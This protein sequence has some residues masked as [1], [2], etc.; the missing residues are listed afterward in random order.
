MKNTDIGFKLILI[1]DRIN[2]KK[3][4]LSFIKFACNLGVKAIQLREK[5]LE[6]RKLL[7]LANSLRKITSK[8]DTLLIINDRIDVALLSNADGLHS[9]VDGLI[10]DDIKRYKTKFIFGK[11]VHSKISA[12]Q[13]EKFGFDYLILGPVFAT[14][15]KKKYGKPL[16]LSLLKEICKSVNIP[17][18]A[19][20]GITP[21]RAKKCKDSGA[22]GVAVIRSLMDSQNLQH[23]INEYKTILCSL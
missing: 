19:I 15:S 10:P 17:V 7:E 16:G 1:T 3:P 20:G 2:T 12:L 6:S 21:D 13:A 14:P 4:F 8:N 18:F 9:P 5:D 23:T 22:Y 11:S